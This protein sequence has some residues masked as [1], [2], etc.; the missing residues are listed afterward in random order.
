MNRERLFFYFDFN[1]DIN[2]L[3]GVV[4]VET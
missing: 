3:W 2:E 4:V 1:G